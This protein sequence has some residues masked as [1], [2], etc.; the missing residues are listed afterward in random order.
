M[1]RFFL[2]REVSPRETSLATWGFEEAEVY[3]SRQSF[4]LTGYHPRL[5][6]SANQPINEV[7]AQL[8]TPA[9]NKTREIQCI[10][11]QAITQRVS[12]SCDYPTIHM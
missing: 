7:Y 9:R 1:G 4:H 6:N 3:E 2:F 11:M 5:D 8:K 12:T 10:Y